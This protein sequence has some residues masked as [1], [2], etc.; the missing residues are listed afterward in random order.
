MR[1]YIVTF[2]LIIW[3]SLIL[4]LSFQGGS[5]TANTSYD[6]TRFVLNIFSKA[7]ID[8]GT[9]MLWDGRFRLSAHFILF[10]LYEIIGMAM[11]KE[12]GL[13]VGPFSIAVIGSGFL[14]AVFTEVGKLL[15]DG[16][17]CD[18][19][20]MGLNLIGVLVGIIVALPFLVWWHKKCSKK[21]ATGC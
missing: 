11:I 9:L 21:N 17:H 20:E 4:F 16:R 15:I 1:K 5:S 10:F 14:L 18:L 8:Y 19:P 2:L 6:F 7:E 12:Y 13:K 3:V